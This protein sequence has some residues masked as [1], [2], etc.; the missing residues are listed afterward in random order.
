[1]WDFFIYVGK[2][3]KFD[4]ELRDEILSAT[5]ILQII[6][7]L[8][9]QGYQVTKDNF[10]TLP[11]LFETLIQNKTDCLGTIRCNRSGVPDIIK[12]AELKK[13]EHIMVYKS[14]S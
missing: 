5:V 9:N 7:S 11:S 8:L 13:G 2:D 6:K 12:K 10:F 4:N 14:I 3:T 1:M